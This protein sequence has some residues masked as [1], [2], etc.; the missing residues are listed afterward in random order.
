MPGQAGLYIVVKPCVRRNGR[1]GGSEE[2]AKKNRAAPNMLG[3][4]CFYSQTLL[5]H[6]D[7]A[8]F[9]FYQVR[10]LLDLHGTLSP[11]RKRA[12]EMAQQLKM[13]ARKT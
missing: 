11:K 9:D 1:R 3:V 2:G 10:Y 12:S 8:I 7:K 5:N 6:E 4:V 13:F